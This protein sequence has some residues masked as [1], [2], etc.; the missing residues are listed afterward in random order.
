MGL[1]KLRY[2]HLMLA[3]YVIIISIL[4]FI[5][6]PLL[7]VKDD[8]FQPK[9]K[10]DTINIT[11]NIELILKDTVK[12]DYHQR[13]KFY[14]LLPFALGINDS[15]IIYQS[16]ESILPYLR[17]L[18]ILNNSVTVDIN[19]Q[20]NYINL[21]QILT[22][23][24]LMKNTSFLERLFM[25]IIPYEISLRIMKREKVVPEERYMNNDNGGEMTAI[26]ISLSA[27]IRSNYENDIN[28][29]A[30][31]KFVKVLFNSAM[32]IKEYEKYNKDYD[33][34]E[35]KTILAM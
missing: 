17:N 15:N 18:N 29:H 2:K 20:L 5:S 23:S 16:G 24:F 34:K 4:I 27:F 9:D 1:I 7:T 13:I 30:I 25:R 14:K 12:S 22:Q 6:L 31:D 33:K 21:V 32:P 3:V 10:Y 11:R 26:L 28:T 19:T 8:I 35:I